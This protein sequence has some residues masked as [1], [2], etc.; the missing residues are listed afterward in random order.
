MRAMPQEIWSLRRAR[1]D[2][3]ARQGC[4]RLLRNPVAQQQH[5]HVAGL[6]PQQQ[7]AGCCEI[8]DPVH[9]LHLAQNGGQRRT[10]RPF[11]QPPED[12]L[13]PAW[14]HGHNAARIESEL[15]KP[16]TV[17]PSFLAK[18]LGASN[19]KDHAFSL[20]HDPCQKRKGKAGDSPAIPTL[21]AHHLM[22]RVK[23]QGIVAKHRIKGLDAKPETQG[24][25]ICPLR[26][27]RPLL[28][29]GGD[30]GR[31]KPRLGGEATLQI[32]NAA[33]QF[34]KAVALICP[35]LET[36]VHVSSSQHKCSLFVLIDSGTL[37]ASQAPSDPVFQMLA[38][39]V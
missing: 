10:S 19:P 39:R 23:A 24:F 21:F 1:R 3:P 2:A 34:T 16:R 11:L 30:R 18:N 37:P 28:H 14:K 33:A 15:Q 9:A 8:K 27:D 12:I 38:P 17:K 32:R 13:H 7:T 6:R 36:L 22:Q 5:R 20:P 29:G 4:C 35:F 25:R 26:K 31:I